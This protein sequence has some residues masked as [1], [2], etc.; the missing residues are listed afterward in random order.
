MGQTTNSKI[1]PK[2]RSVYFNLDDEDE[3]R[4]YEKAGKINFSKWVKKQLSGNTNQTKERV[5][6]RVD[7]IT[8]KENIEMDSMML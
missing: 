7:K 1:K 2:I 3:L 4:L 8:T 5:G 6:N